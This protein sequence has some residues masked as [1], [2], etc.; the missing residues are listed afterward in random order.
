MNNNEDTNDEL[1]PEYNFDYSQAKPNKFAMQ[2]SPV[3]G[4][5]RIVLYGDYETFN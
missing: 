1:L 4:D 2:Q 5:S 3:I